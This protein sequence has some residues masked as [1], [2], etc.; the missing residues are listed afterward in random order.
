[1]K[2]KIYLTI[3]IDPE[4]YPIPADE[5]VGQDIQDSREEQFYDIDGEDIRHIKTIM[6]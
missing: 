5:N 3:D 6:E 1:M 4:E 2:V